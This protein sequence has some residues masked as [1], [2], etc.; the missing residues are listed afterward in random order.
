LRN[1]WWPI[2]PS[3][4]APNL[5]GLVAQEDPIAEPFRLCGE[6]LGQSREIVHPLNLPAMRLAIELLSQSRASRQTTRA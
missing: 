3:R 1:R 6:K 5:A 4:F 2:L